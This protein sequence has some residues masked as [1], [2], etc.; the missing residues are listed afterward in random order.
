[1]EGEAGTFVLLIF[2]NQSSTLHLSE[3]DPLLVD[4]KV[5]GRKEKA[6]DCQGEVSGNESFQEG[7]D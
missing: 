4:A 2:V 7:K 6:R 5:Y 1:M 3:S